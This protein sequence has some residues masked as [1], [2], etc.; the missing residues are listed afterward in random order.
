MKTELSPPD[1]NETAVFQNQAVEFALILSRMINT[2]KEDPSQM[3]LAIYEFARARLKTDTSWANDGERKQLLSSLEAAIRGVEDF[4]VRGGD[5]ARIEASTQAPQLPGRKTQEEPPG[6]SVVE[7]HRPEPPQT[8]VPG[9]VV[10]SW[11]NATPAAGVQAARLTSRPNRFWIGLMLF[12]AAVAGTAIYANM[13]L[14]FALGRDAEVTKAASPASAEPAAPP[15]SAQSPPPTS[16][17]FETKSAAAATRPFPLPTDYGVYALSSAGLSELS[18]LPEQVPDKRVSI[19]TPIS[20]SS[21]TTLPDGKAKFVVYRRDLAGN[22][23]ERMDVRVVA[24]VMRALKFDAK[25]KPVISPVSDAWN[26]RNLSYEFRVRPIA[27]NP[28]MLLVQPADSE[29]TLPAGRYALA[30]RNQGYDFTVAGEITDL[31]QCLERT[32]AVNGSFYSDCRKP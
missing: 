30:L 25:G 13:Q 9:K 18:P 14:I 5:Q 1:G 24:K 11:D 31:S 27:G 7:I 3:R 4:A 23:P 19:S 2:V 22:A 15:A 28:E 8:I 17:A 26:I 6:M 10:Y 21:S 32:D 12:F 29:F 20:Q 16:L